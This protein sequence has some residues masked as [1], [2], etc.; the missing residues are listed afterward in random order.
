MKTLM[1]T[2][3]LIVAGLMCAPAWSMIASVAPA[4][5]YAAD[6]ATTTSN[7]AKRAATSAAPAPTAAIKPASA[8][9]APDVPMRTAPVAKFAVARDKSVIVPGGATARSAPKP[10]AASAAWTATA[11]G[12]TSMR[13]GTVQTINVSKGTLQVYGQKLAFDAQRVKVFNR[14]GKPGS[15]FAVKNGTPVH[16]TMDSTDKAQRRVAVIWLE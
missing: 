3:V 13:R 12:G 16:F 6:K 1:N 10:S 14:D 4:G 15:V 8:L 11:Q 7:A 2:I 5:T 9:A